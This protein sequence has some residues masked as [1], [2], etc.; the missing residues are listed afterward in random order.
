MTVMRNLG[1][2]ELQA[3]GRR[4]EL[5]P[6]FDAM[7]A[8]ATRICEAKFGTL[9]LRDGEAFHAASLHNAPSA[10]AE[11]RKRG[12]MR[13]GP[14]NALGRLIRTNQ[15]VLCGHQAGS[16][17]RLPSRREL[18][19]P[20]RARRIHEELSGRVTSNGGGATAVASI[21]E[22]T[23]AVTT[24]TATDPDAGQTLTYS[25][26][27]GGD[28]GKFTIGSTTGALSFITVPNFE[29]PNDA[30]GNNVYDVTV[31]VSD[32]NGGSDTQ[33]IAVTVTDQN[34]AT[35]MPLNLIVGNDGSLPKVHS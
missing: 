11:D 20:A 34:E 23:I 18:R 19:F 10:F 22:N 4:G 8:N 16:G 33:A 5:Q 2:W 14:R 3:R 6:V 24:V 1:K 12:L 9:Y 31:Q 25:I 13:P 21:A 28:A 32:G 26:T 7:L 35:A 29:A 15:V 30:G 17:W 27:G